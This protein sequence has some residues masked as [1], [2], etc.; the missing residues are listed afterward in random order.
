M[1]AARLP[2]ACSLAAPEM[3]ARRDGL[4]AE[5]RR[6]V[7]ETKR[8]PGGIAL[9]FP[10]AA[11]W[12]ETLAGL[13]ALERECCRFLRFRLSAEPD[14]GPLWLSVTGPRG[15]AEFLRVELGLAA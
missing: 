9:R 7:E 2:V 11:R 12:V 13:M 4:V 10:G 3:R 8:V 14:G 1:A 6:G 15:T 5:V